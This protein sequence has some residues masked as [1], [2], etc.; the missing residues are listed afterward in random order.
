[1][2]GVA[3]L[4]LG[5]WWWIGV[6]LMILFCVTLIWSLFY[7]GRHG[8]IDLGCSTLDELIKSDVDDADR[9]GSLNDVDVVVALETQDRTT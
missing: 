4:R 7:M 5:G 2:K 3:V 8:P 6:G 1:M 9:P